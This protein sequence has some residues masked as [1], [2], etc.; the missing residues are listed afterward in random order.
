MKVLKRNGKKEEYNVEKIHKIVGWAIEGING[1]TLSDIEINANLQIKDGI[2][3]TEI[4]NV[5]IDS[6][7]NLISLK[8]P[9]YQYVASRLL[10][11]QLRKYV[12]GG[13]TPP[14]LLDF[15][16]K[17]INVNKVYDHK[18]LE[19]YSKTEINKLG[20]YI[21]HDR[22]YNFTYSGLRQ[23]CDKYLIQHRQTGEIYETLT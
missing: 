20:E 16:E 4:H 12:W 1:V 22:D 11:Y 14:K 17:N 8:K 5:L 6:A 9:N 19:T 2:T 3:S 18:I 23:L 13:K 7:V 10:S 15:I 21:N